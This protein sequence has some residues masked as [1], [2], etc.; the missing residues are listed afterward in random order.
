MKLQ[1]RELKAARLT[2]LLKASGLARAYFRFWLASSFPT[3]SSP[4]SLSPSPPPL[5]CPLTA[6][7]SLSFS[8]PLFTRFPFRI[9]P[10]PALPP[11]LPLSSFLPFSLPLVFLFISA[12]LISYRGNPRVRFA[13]R[14]RQRESKFLV[15]FFGHRFCFCILIIGP[16]RTIGHGHYRRQIVSYGFLTYVRFA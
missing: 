7:L 4:F 14:A 12:G 11:S 1:L 6:I 5:P 15:S 8:P 10:Y 9:S 13:L 2:M 16:W 3:S